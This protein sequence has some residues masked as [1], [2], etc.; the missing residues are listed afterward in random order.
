MLKGDGLHWGGW[1]AQVRVERDAGGGIGEG[2][3]RVN[4]R[5][6]G[7]GKRKL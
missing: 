5:V 7:G 2:R 3:R 1:F 4:V 6:G